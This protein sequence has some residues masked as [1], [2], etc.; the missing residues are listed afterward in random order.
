MHIHNLVSYSIAY[1]STTQLQQTIF[2]FRA[3]SAIALAGSPKRWQDVLM[4]LKN[5]IRG[6]NHCSNKTVLVPCSGNQPKWLNY[7]LRHKLWSF[8][9]NEIFTIFIYRYIISCNLCMSENTIL[10]YN[11]APNKVTEHIV[12][13]EWDLIRELLQCNTLY[14]NRG[15][16]WDGNKHPKWI[17]QT[18]Y[19]LTI[20]I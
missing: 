3:M 18:P 15:D 10:N 6:H 16:I 1:H 7:L 11:R 5:I 12:N 8:F 20:A 9:M 17:Y 2:H 14:L 13:C 4:S 19:L